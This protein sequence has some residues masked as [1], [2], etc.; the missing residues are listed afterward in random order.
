VTGGGGGV[1]TPGIP[2][3]VM[4]T[5]AGSGNVTITWNSVANASSYNVYRKANSSVTTSNFDQKMGVT[6]THASFTTLASPSTQYF[7]V[8]AANSSGESLLSEVV[9]TSICSSQ[10]TA[11]TSPTVTESSNSCFATAA[12]ETVASSTS[13]SNVSSS[14]YFIFSGT[15]QQG[16]NTTYS[17]IVQ[18]NTSTPTL[19][20]ISLSCTNVSSHTAQYIL[21]GQNVTS[22]S[23]I[24][25][26][27][28]SSTTITWNAVPNVDFYIVSVKTTDSNGNIH[29]TS[30]TIS[31]SNT[32]TPVSTNSGD[33]YN[34]AIIIGYTSC[35]LSTVSTASSH[36]SP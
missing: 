6:V 3:N 15:G 24:T 10:P 17:G 31:S 4:V 22:T 19:T 14:T 1:G 34:S 32:S 5:N 28:G 21:S 7:G 33:T 23:N 27:V 2:Q 35:N 25:S 8:T 13:N 11:P 29:Y 12:S 20:G 36:V 30:S 26:P 18:G 16:S 9:S